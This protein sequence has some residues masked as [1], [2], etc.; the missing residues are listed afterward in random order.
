MLELLAMVCLGL[1][2]LIPNHFPPWTSFYNETCAALAV[3]FLVIAQRRRLLTQALPPVVWVVTACAAIPWLQWL[4]G[5]LAFSGDALLSSLYLVGSATAI[6]AGTMWARADASPAMEL[7]CGT[8]VTAAVVASVLGLT[9][10]LQVGPASIWSLDA[11]P[12]MRAYANL[13]QP[14]NL[15]T[16]LGLGLLGVLLLHERDRVGKVG[17]IMLAALLVLGMAPTQSRTALLFGPAILLG[18]WIASRRGLMLKTSLRTIGG[19]LVIHVALTWLWPAIQ[20]QL[21][22]EGAASL[23]ARASGNS[24]RLLMW[25]LFFDA[26]AHSPWFGFGWLQAGKALLLATEQGSAVE[27]WMHGHN[28]FLDLLVWCG[29]PVGLALSALVLYWYGS[30]AIAIRTMNSVVS[31][32]AVTLV[33]I[34]AMVELAHHYAYFL[35]PVGLWIGQIEGEV[36]AA[37]TLRQRWNAVPVL[38]SGFM[39]FALWR[40]YHEVEEDFRLMRFE[41]LHIGTVRATQPAPDAPFLSGLTEFLRFSRTEPAAG[42]GPSQLQRM[43]AVAKRYPYA[44]SL[45][46]WARALALN[47]RL[48][49]ARRV[50]NQLRRLHGDAYYARLGQDLRQRVEDGELG[51]QSLLQALPE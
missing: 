47:G 19:L 2:W 28:L 34:H 29:Y 21:L 31:M 45:Y 43:E 42:M 51:L 14:N 22:L 35:V 15:A 17:S 5:Q 33:G 50:L 37:R 16:L 20:Q 25:P 12:G 23:S 32:L 46:R 24:V 7:L 10:A 13:A 4:S 38:L 49:E 1:A 44:P 6:A 41:V 11:Y 9:Q 3:L 18:L 40:D 36:V 48:P 27:F 8:V 39:M 30:R 26:L